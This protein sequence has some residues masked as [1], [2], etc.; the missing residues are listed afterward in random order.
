ML[1]GLGVK[2]RTLFGRSDEDDDGDVNTHEHEQ[3]RRHDGHDE[4]EQYPFDESHNHQQGYQHYFHHH[5][6]TTADHAAAGHA[7]TPFGARTSLQTEN[8]VSPMRQARSQHMILKRVRREVQEVEEEEEEKSTSLLNIHANRFT[9]QQDVFTFTREFARETFDPNAQGPQLDT[10]LPSLAREIS[11]DSRTTASSAAAGSSSAA[12]GDVALPR[13]D[14]G[15]H[16]GASATAAGSSSNDTSVAASGASLNLTS[17]GAGATTTRPKQRKFTS[18]EV[19]RLI[20]EAVSVR[21]AQLRDEF[22]RE[23]NRL[24]NEQFESFSR[25]CEDQRNLQLRNSTAPYIS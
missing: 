6:G 4:N 15:A 17:A 20:A 5:A 13:V 12:A 9:P 21:E 11:Q 18:A 8:Y 16:M 1:L 25:Y 14:S 24:L 10:E 19:Q 23:L 7:P 22:A 2:R 3:L